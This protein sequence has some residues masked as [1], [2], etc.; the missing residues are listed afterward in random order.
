[1]SKTFCGISIKLLQQ[2]SEETSDYLDST[3]RGAAPRNTAALE[4]S[5]HR[6]R[7]NESVAGELL[8]GHVSALFGAVSRVLHQP[9]SDGNLGPTRFRFS[10]GST[11]G[12][13]HRRRFPPP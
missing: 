12:A 3:Q 5:G 10:S 8:C 11:R 4:V 9:K 1:M 6:R 13:R 2:R 7:V